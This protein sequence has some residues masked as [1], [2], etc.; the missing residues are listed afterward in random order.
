MYIYIHIYIYIYILFIYKYIYKCVLAEGQNALKI[1]IP[2]GCSASPY[3][4]IV[5]QISMKSR[6]TVQQI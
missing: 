2:T 6:D 1:N 4:V 5:K 3:L